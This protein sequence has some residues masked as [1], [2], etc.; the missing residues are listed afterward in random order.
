MSLHWKKCLLVIQ[1]ILKLFPNILT[2]DDNHY[3]LNR[4]NLTQSI[5]MKLYEK[6]KKISEFFVRFVKSI[7]NF[8]HMPKNYGPHK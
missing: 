7:L 2:V 3:L 8:K 1:K 4:D 6:E 5:Q